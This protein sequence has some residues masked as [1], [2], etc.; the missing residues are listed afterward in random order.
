MQ[1]VRVV[2]IKQVNRSI[3]ASVIFM[4]I[5]DSDIKGLKICCCPPHSRRGCLII[6]GLGSLS[7]SS[8]HWQLLISTMWCWS[9][10]GYASSDLD[11]TPDCRH[12]DVS[13]CTTSMMYYKLLKIQSG[14]IS[15]KNA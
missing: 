3:P 6:F 1:Q 2:V 11:N 14:Q 13:T 10:P 7:P 5:G 4:T 8:E 15:S 12:Y 9:C